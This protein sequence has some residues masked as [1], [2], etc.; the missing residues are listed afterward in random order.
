MDSNAGEFR[1]I[2]NTMLTGLSNYQANLFTLQD[3]IPPLHFSCTTVAT[4]STYVASILFISLSDFASKEHVF[5]NFLIIFSRLMAG[6]RS[7]PSFHTLEFPE[8]LQNPGAKHSSCEKTL[9]AELDPSLIQSCE[10]LRREMKKSYIL[11]V[12]IIIAMGAW[13]IFSFTHLDTY[14]AIHFYNF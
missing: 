3:C 9:Q 2:L 7:T 12:F 8:L 1:R 4:F 13:Q 5:S 11:D 6:I 14:S 10:F